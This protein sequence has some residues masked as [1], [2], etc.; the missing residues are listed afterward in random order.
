MVN[1]N[2]ALHRSHFIFQENEEVIRSKGTSTRQTK[3]LLETTTTQ[4][5]TEGDSETCG[6]AET[7]S[8]LHQCP[9][10]LLC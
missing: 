4:H 10:D 3:E 7:R 1:H 2:T 6:S 5:N 8:V 9:S